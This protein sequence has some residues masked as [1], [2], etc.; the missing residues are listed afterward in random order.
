ML[1]STYMYHVSCYMLDPKL[2]GTKK[3]EQGDWKQGRMFKF[4]LTTCRA[5]ECRTYQSFN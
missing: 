4:I 5:E 2:K 3:K 1:I